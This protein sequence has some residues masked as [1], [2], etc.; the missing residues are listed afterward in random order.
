[1][2]ESNESHEHG[3][4]HVRRSVVHH[5]A[6]F[7]GQLSNRMQPGRYTLT[8]IDENNSFEAKKTMRERKHPQCRLDACA[9]VRKPVSE[10]DPFLPDFSPEK[11]T[12]TRKPVS[13]QDPFLPDFSTEK[14]TLVSKPVSEDDPFLP[15]F[16]TEKP[17]LTS[18]PV[19]EQ[20]RFS[21]KCYPPKQP[22][23]RENNHITASLHDG[24]QKTLESNSLS[25][26]WHLPPNVCRHE[27][28][29]RTRRHLAVSKH[30]SLMG[31]GVS[32]Q[33]KNSTQ[34]EDDSSLKC[35]R[36]RRQD[37]LHSGVR[38]GSENGLNPKRVI[39]QQVRF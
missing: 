28:N 3:N 8:P 34:I 12:F 9:T 30:P 2:D 31:N 27:N 17:T 16:S 14:L 24:S 7:D 5:E 20:N 25:E 36:V 37:S 39:A 19:S 1:M 21:A 35:K 15:D 29:V 11:P 4:V 32:T 23:S 22:I 33:L 18:K 10:A 26:Q 13:E 38:S 6:H